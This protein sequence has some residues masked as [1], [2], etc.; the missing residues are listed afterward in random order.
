MWSASEETVQLVITLDDTSQGANMLDKC[1][2]R[3]LSHQA[4]WIWDQRQG[5]LT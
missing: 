1:S 3:A 4:A 5:G 2:H